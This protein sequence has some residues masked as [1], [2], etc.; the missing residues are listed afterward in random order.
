[1]T[2]TGRCLCGQVK[3]AIAGEPLDARMCWCRVC[4]KIASGSATVNVFFPADSV[5]FSGKITAAIWSRAAFARNA[6]RTSTA[7]RSN[8]PDSRSGSAPEPS[9]TP[10]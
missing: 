3:Y 4:Q 10:S 7:A 9:T 1:M 5:Q 6:A 8:I 2:H